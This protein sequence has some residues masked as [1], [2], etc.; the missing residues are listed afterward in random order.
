M[1]EIQGPRLIECR[2]LDKLKV[3][4][5]IEICPVFVI[6]DVMMIYTGTTTSPFHQNRDV[7]LFFQFNVETNTREFGQRIN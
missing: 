3:Q 4:R 2:D 6:P 7:T 1:K 5:I